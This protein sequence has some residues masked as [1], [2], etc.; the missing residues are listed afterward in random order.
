[1]IISCSTYK[2][3]HCESEEEFICSNIH[4]GE[5]RKLTEQTPLFL[6]KYPAQSP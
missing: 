6:L 2:N 3:R 4:G 5:E 1:M